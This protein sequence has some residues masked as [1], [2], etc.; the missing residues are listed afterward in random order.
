V[1]DTTRRGLSFAA[2]ALLWR[3]ET[4]YSFEIIHYYGCRSGGPWWRGICGICAEQGG[5]GDAELYHGIIDRQDYRTGK[6]AAAFI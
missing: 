1:E 2:H 4:I 6:K 3:Y 5:A